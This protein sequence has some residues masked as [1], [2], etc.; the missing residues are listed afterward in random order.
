MR[1]IP[2]R[3]HT[4]ADLAYRPRQTAQTAQY[5][6]DG[7]IPGHVALQTGTDTDLGT[8]QNQDRHRIDEA[9]LQS[10]ISSLEEKIKAQAHEIKEVR[11]MNDSNLTAVT[12]W[13]RRANTHQ[14]YVEELQQQ[15]H[16]YEAEIDELKKAFS[17]AGSIKDYATDEDISTQ[18][19]MIYVSIEEWAVKIVQSIESMLRLTLRVP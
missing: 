7:A 4:S 2:N 17:A 8:P 3:L 19:R 9:E 12:T 15:L 13:K 5:P 10:F 6:R 14:Q 18:F 1:F 11:R 16:E